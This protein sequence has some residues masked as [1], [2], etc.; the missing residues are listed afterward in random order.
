M[1][2]E[3]SSICTNCRRHLK[4]WSEERRA[5]WKGCNLLLDEHSG[6]DDPEK[7]GNDIFCKEMAMGWVING[8]M[9]INYQIL[10]KG[11]TKCRYF[12]QK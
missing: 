11:T 4:A 1:E 2:N 10:T 6:V 7:T 8:V 3:V 12:Q 5:E 9:A